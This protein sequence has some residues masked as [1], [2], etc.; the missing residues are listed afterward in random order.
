MSAPRDDAA[1]LGHFRD[2]VLRIESYVEDVTEDEFF[3]TPLIQDGVIR[4]IQIIGEATKRL[5]IGLRE[6]TPRIPWADIAGMRDKIVHDY[7]GVDLETVWETATKDVPMLESQ[8]RKLIE[9]QPP[10][11]TQRLDSPG[12]SG[13]PL[14]SGQ[15]V[16]VGPV[17]DSSPPRWSTSLSEHFHR[18]AAR[19]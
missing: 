14:A 11:V 17:S 16:R 3:K 2:A 5:S 12:G 18:R 15:G 19:G 7:M 6:R 4:Q 10:E 9:T 13:E 8:L 1:Y